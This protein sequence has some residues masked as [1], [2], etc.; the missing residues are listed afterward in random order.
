MEDNSYRLIVAYFE[1]TISDEELT[2]LREWIELYPGNQEQFWET[3]QILEASKSYFKKTDQVGTASWQRI[4]AHI[5]KE[6]KSNVGRKIHWLAYAA[7]ILII[8]S[9]SL[10]WYKHSSYK[11]DT[12]V[13]Y[14]EVINPEG[15]QSKILLPDSSVIYLAGGSKIKYRKNFSGNKR[16]VSLEGEAFFEV[17]HGKK[18]F[19]IQSGEIATVVLGTSFNVRAFASDH[20]VTVT[21]NSGKVGVMKTVRGKNHLIKYLTPNEQIEINTITGLYAFD[22]ANA[23]DVSAWIKNHFVFYDVPIREVMASLEH[24]Y[25]VRIEFIE[26]EIG[27]SRVTA[28]FKNMPLK[29]VMDELMVL[30][31]LTYIEKNGHIFIYSVNQKGGKIMN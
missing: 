25:G 20:K 31:G 12:A 27:N 19:M 9:M 30:S 26:P 8:G 6:E 3:M 15:Q 7:S 11:A 22:T 10:W 1:K 24:R 5:Q 13:A 23:A 4:N 2:E 16:S 29:D 28:K 14:T 18:P 17:M 21:V